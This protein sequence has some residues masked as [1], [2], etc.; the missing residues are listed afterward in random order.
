[1]C[2]QEIS[3]SRNVRRGP[4]KNEAP[5]SSAPYMYYSIRVMHSQ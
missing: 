4:P 1:M 2:N 3:Q 5:Q